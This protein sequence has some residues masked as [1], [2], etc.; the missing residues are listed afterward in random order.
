MRYNQFSMLPER[1]FQKRLGLFG[2][3]PATLEGG[4][5]G[6]I[7]AVV[8]VVATVAL[9]VAT[10]GASLAAEAAIDGG[11]IAADGAVAAGEVA[12]ADAV[13]S[14][15]AD[16]AITTGTE[17]AAGTA[18]ADTAVATGADVAASE[19]A[20]V[21]GAAAA[22]E[23]A[24][25]AGEGAAAA[26]GEGA[27]S[28]GATAAG[29]AA[30]N[31]SAQQALQNAGMGALKS[32]GMNSLS[33]LVSTGSIDPNKALKAGVTGAVGA[34]LGSGLSQLGANPLVANALAGTAAGATGASL[35]GTDVG[36]GALI[37]GAG[38]A[39]A[40][41]SQM[42]GQAAGLDPTVQ[43]ALTGAVRGATLSGINNGSIGTGAL[44]GGIVGGASSIGNQVG[45]AAQNAATG[46]TG[47]SSLL[48]QVLGGVAGYEAKSALNPSAATT[49]Y[50]TPATQA[51]GSL[52]S[53]STGIPTAAVQA[54]NQ[55]SIQNQA[56]INSGMSGTTASGLSNLALAGSQA[57]IPTGSSVNFNTGTASNSAPS[58]GLNNNGLPAAL[59]P[60]VLASNPLATA[61]QSSNPQL[62]QLLQLHP[63]LGSVDPRILASLMGSSPQG[64]KRG[65][66][67]HMAIGGSSQFETAQ[68]LLGIPIVRESAAEQAAY[69]NPTG[70]HHRPLVA[71]HFINGHK[72][73]GQIEH[74]PEFITGKTGHHVK[75]RG[76]G[77]SDEIP[78]MLANDEYVFD[79]D[80]VAALGDGSSEAG[81]KFLDHFRQSVRA[82]KRAA[83]V[84]KIPPKASP[85]QYVKE[86]IKK[87]R[88]A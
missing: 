42:I 86:A 18:A 81:A 4:G 14:A 11:A 3:A 33:Q 80:T 20:T 28:A 65:G 60:G 41:G 39:A 44:T 32:A 46:E 35:N 69:G 85:L 73:G 43:G 48:G 8:A 63:Q 7:M 13:T 66:V 2:S 47:N 27:T 50:N 36:R 58:S 54:Q 5:G 22:G 17:A 76:T 67:V 9:A 87:T 30:S 15:A 23:G 75:G 25:A 64:Y 56:G 40:G 34:G 21:E 26:A 37:G 55:S 19:A 61:A 29:D 70:G 57:G 53:T 6:G 49:S 83:P 77:Q 45:T 79:A 38:G 62:E 16:A 12:T 51:S 72:K 71:T 82:H 1:A 84:D 59:T 88:N 10:D 31:F 52:K 74:I 78:A 68:Q 24:T